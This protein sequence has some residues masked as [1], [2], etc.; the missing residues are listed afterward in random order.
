MLESEFEITALPVIS[1]AV[2]GKLLNLFRPQ[3]Q[4]L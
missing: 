1:S 2:L 3:L 4:H